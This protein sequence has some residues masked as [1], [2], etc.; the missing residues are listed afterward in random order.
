MQDYMLHI[1]FIMLSNIVNIVVK[2]K[3][4]MPLVFRTTMVD[5]V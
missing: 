1:R 5:N 4:I 2:Y 3:I